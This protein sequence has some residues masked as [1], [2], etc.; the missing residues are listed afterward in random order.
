MGVPPPRRHRIDTR[1]RSGFSDWKAAAI[2][3][4]HADLGRL[5]CVAPRG[6]WCWRHGGVRAP[7][8][9]EGRCPPHTPTGDVGARSQ[10][11]GWPDLPGS[12]SRCPS[13]AL[14]PLPGDVSHRA[15][16]LGG[17]CIWRASPLPRR[18]GCRVHGS[19]CSLC[20]YVFRGDSVINTNVDVLVTSNGPRRDKMHYI[21]NSAVLLC[22]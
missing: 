11:P 22:I 1:E 19:G 15:M 5:C 13:A 21:K 20:H 10:T 7:G 18:P 9:A 6:R 14:W 4:G 8:R 17:T 16:R 3:L 2:L 12:T